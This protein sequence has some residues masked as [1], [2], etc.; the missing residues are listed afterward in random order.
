MENRRDEDVCRFGIR[1]VLE[2]EE[3]RGEGEYI[4]NQERPRDQIHNATTAVIYNRSRPRL[5]LLWLLDPRF[6]VCQPRW[7]LTG[8]ALQSTKSIFVTLG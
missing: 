8:R 1:Q 3:S 6:F 5:E 7:I 2:V 4:L